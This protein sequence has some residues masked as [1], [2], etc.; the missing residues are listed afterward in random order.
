MC[1]SH[2]TQFLRVNLNMW[3]SQGLNLKKTSQNSDIVVSHIQI[4]VRYIYLRVNEKSILPV[5]FNFLLFV[6]FLPPFSLRSFLPPFFPSL[7]GAHFVVLV[8]NSL[9]SPELSSD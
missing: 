9:Y 6:S 5:C 7:L 8:W 3:R 2:S 1:S 4:C